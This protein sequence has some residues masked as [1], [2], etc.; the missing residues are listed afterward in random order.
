MRGGL[1]DPH[2]G[3][4]FTNMTSQMH[5]HAGSLSDGAPKS[6][7]LIDLGQKSCLFLSSL[8]PSF[9]PIPGEDATWGWRGCFTIH[10]L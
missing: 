4:T 6:A 10:F 3:E 5:K 2:I 8:N 7:P 9:P 1:C